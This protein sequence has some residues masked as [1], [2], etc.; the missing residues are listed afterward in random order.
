[1]G[2]CEHKRQMA[3]DWLEGGSNS[4]TPVLGQPKLSW[5]QHVWLM[6]W[7][8]FQMLLKYAVRNH[9][10]IS[11][12]CCKDEARAF[13]PVL[14]VALNFIIEVS[15]HPEF[16]TTGTRSDWSCSFSDWQWGMCGRSWEWYPLHKGKK[17]VAWFW[18]YSTTRS[19][20]SRHFHA[21]CSYHSLVHL[22]V[23]R[24]SFSCSMSNR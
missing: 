22:N 6:E 7:P 19:Y 21:C 14:S 10:K 18:M 9:T 1:M 16:F 13:V 12:S 8:C 24:H 17:P 11:V 3:E 23:S 20:W 4:I 2:K 5:W 15:S